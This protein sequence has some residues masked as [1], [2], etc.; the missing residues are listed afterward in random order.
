MS[1]SLSC[2]GPLSSAELQQLPSFA[3]PSSAVALLRRED[4][5]GGASVMSRGDHRE[6]IFL[7]DADRLDVIKTLGEAW[8]KAGWQVHAYG[9]IRSSR[10]WRRG[11]GGRR[12]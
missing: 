5:Y 11:C 9:L 10:R 6:K 4:G 8:Q 1:L 12:R 2:R 3:D 7:D